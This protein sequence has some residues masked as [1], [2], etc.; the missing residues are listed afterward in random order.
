MLINKKALIETEGFWGKK[1]ALIDKKGSMK[2]ELF[3]QRRKSWFKK[4]PLS[5]EEHHLISGNTCWWK[6]NAW[7]KK[8]D[9]KELAL[10]GERSVLL[11]WEKKTLI[12]DIDE[13]KWLLI[14][15]E[16]AISQTRRWWTK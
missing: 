8:L 13:R 5:K 12:K 11:I 14:E 15:E 1:N 2:A 4:D 3:A 10:N 6:G 16:D 7:F 9:L